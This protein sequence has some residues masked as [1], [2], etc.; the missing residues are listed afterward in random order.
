[1]SILVVRDVI[2]KVTLEV[3]SHLEL[4]LVLYEGRGDYNLVVVSN[5]VSFHVEVAIHLEELCLKL[6]AFS[7]VLVR[8]ADAHLGGQGVDRSSVRGVHL[9]GTYL[10]GVQSVKAPS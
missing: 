9:I 1:L 8:C 4:G 5:A 2:I 7:K 10:K 3:W 6:V